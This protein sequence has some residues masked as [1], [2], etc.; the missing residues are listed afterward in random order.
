VGTGAG[1]VGAVATVVKAETGSTTGA[2]AG[3]T[4]VKAETGAVVG[5]EN[6]ITG[7]GVIVVVAKTGML[8]VGAKTGMSGAG[9]GTGATGVGTGAKGA[10]AGAKGAVAGAK[11]AVAGATVAENKVGPV[12]GREPPAAAGA[13]GT[14]SAR[15]T[16]GGV[17]V[18]DGPVMLTGIQPKACEVPMAGNVVGA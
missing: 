3:A 16:S 1:R 6:G 5:P 10:V 2:A 8:R 11:G 9:T 15:W 13:A 17:Q 12:I 4:V 18:A 7:A 14:P